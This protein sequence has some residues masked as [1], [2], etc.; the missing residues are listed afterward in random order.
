MLLLRE[1]SGAKRFAKRSGK[2]R[3][4]TRPSNE[5][6]VAEHRLQLQNPCGG[7]FRFLDPTEFRESAGMRDI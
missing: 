1:A 7:G 3:R 6:T 4:A 2:R 5:L